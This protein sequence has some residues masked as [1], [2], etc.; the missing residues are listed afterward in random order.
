MPQNQAMLEGGEEDG[1]R[2]GWR[3]RRPHQLR[4]GRL[5]RRQGVRTRER[6]S[7]YF[8]FSSLPTFFR[9]LF[10]SQTSFLIEL[11]KRGIEPQSQFNFLF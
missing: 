9:P 8:I 7:G 3:Q 5:R 11:Q 2:H 6:G 10:S 1:D 4:R